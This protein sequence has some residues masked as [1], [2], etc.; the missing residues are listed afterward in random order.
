MPNPQPKER[1]RVLRSIRNLTI[2]YNHNAPYYELIKDGTLMT[3]IL[4]MLE[5]RTIELDVKSECLWI[6]ANLSCEDKPCDYLI[7]EL[8]VV[9]VL[10]LLFDM[11][12]VQG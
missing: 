7:K 10:A 4:N 12:F 5:D 8:G 1:M 11:Y 3:K 2:T 9:N 6:L